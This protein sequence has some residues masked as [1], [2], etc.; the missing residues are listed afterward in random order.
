MYPFDILK[1]KLKVGLLSEY[2]DKKYFLIIDKST[3]LIFLFKIN[4]V[5]CKTRFYL[6]VVFLPPYFLQ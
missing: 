1:K 6:K 3:C 5:R 4:F 2:T